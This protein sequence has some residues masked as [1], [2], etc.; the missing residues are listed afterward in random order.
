MSVDENELTSALEN[1]SENV[2]AVLGN[3]GLA[4]RLDKTVNLANY[5]GENLFP[6]IDEYTGEEK[7]ESWEQLYS[8]Q[9]M[10]TANYAQKKAGNILNMFT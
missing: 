8:A 5:Q 7:I 1:N 4:G 3:E 10:T 6:T 2:N 9:T